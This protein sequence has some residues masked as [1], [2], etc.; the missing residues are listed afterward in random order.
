[1]LNIHQ[2]LLFVIPLIK[3]PSP[4]QTGLIP[5]D[6]P[7]GGMKVDQEGKSTG[8]EREKGIKG[9]CH[10]PAGRQPLHIHAVLP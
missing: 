10:L 4:C 9:V 5:R 7:W 3:K 1:M 8:R 2:S 6:D